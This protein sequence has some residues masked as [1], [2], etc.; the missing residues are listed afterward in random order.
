LFCSRAGFSH[1]D[2][3]PPPG[4]ADPMGPEVVAGVG[5]APTK[6]ELMR[7]TLNLILPAV[8]MA[9]QAAARSVTEAGPTAFVP[10]DSGAAAFAQAILVPGWPAEPEPGAKRRAKAG[11]V[12]G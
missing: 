10:R 2:R 9:C 5:V 3:G 6:V 12:G 4:V 8:K 11:G 7:L 1:L